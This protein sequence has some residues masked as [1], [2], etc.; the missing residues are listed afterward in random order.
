MAV[1]V[2]GSGAWY[3]FGYFGTKGSLDAIEDAAGDEQTSIT[4]T[5]VGKNSQSLEAPKDIDDA[6]PSDFYKDVYFTDEERVNWAYDQLDQPSQEPGYEGMSVLEAAHQKLVEF[7][8][9]P[10]NWEYVKELVEPSENMTG[11]QIYT[12]QSS[13]YFAA[14][15]SELPEN[16]RIKMLAAA[17]DNS[18]PV[19]Q[20]AIKYTI[21]R[22]TERMRGTYAV[23]ISATNDQPVESPVFRHTVLSNGFDPRGIPTKV[24]NG[25][26]T[27]GAQREKIQSIFQFING[28]PVLVETNPSTDPTLRASNPQ[29]IPAN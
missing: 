29:N 27:S 14:V 24:I 8:N 6:A 4:T 25:S 10:G 21:D 3:L 2:V 9:K 13:I 17:I 15:N 16:D 18:N 5:D 1:V 22:D 26:N 11:D 12:L 7:Y 20:D 19:L 23:D 28:K